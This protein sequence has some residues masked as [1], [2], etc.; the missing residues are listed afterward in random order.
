MIRDDGDRRV[1]EGVTV[2]EF[3][4][5]LAGPYCGMLLADM[6]ATVIKVER[7][8]S[9]DLGRTIG[10]LQVH[11]EGATFLSLN[12]NKRSVTLDLGQTEGRQIA[13]ALAVRADVLV[14]NM[15]PGALARW[16]L[17]EPDL[18]PAAPRL[19]Y[20]SISAFGEDGPYA[21]LGGID[22]LVQALGGLMALT[23]E[24]GGPPVMVGAPIADYAGAMNAV[25]G[26]VLAL[27]DRERTGRGR[28]VQVNL[29]NAMIAALLPREW[30]Y[31]ATGQPPAR[32][33]TAHRLMA[34]YQAYQTADG[35]IYLAVL[36]DARFLRLIDAL[37]LAS[38]REDA[39]FRSG[40]LRARHRAELNEFLMPLFRRRPN[41]EWLAELRAI[42]MLVAPVN[43]L[44]QAFRDPQVIHNETVI[45]LKHPTHGPLPSIR[46]GFRLGD[47]PDIPR[48]PPPAL[49]A[50]TA[51]VLAEIGY[52]A[53]WIAELHAQGIV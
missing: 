16:G 6:G 34:P 30:D 50:D 35:W 43:E 13:H 38:L 7:P 14:Q 44:D 11:G 28:L 27:Y 32:M 39:R 45:E 1:L 48:R 22:P 53:G 47:A 23:G 41:H 21:A 51:A 49:G 10:G 25:Q 24:Q 12:R 36:D 4:Q 3:G 46:P 15:Q 20:C 5:F 9:G 18:R 52:S 42:D 19:I 29:L 40:P 31:F 26:I 8:G 2:V 37:G 33:G 17:S